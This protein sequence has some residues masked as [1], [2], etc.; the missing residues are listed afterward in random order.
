[1]CAKCCFSECYT[2]LNILVKEI[3]APSLGRRNIRI[4]HDW[5]NNNMQKLN[6]KILFIKSLKTSLSSFRVVG[7]N[8]SQHSQTIEIPDITL[9]CFPKLEHRT[10]FSKAQNTS[11]TGF[12]E[13]ELDLVQKSPTLMTISHINWRASA[14]YHGRKTVDSPTEL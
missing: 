5:T 11:E 10:L 8:I 3:F 2:S 13:I 12:W 6:I 7:Q 4:S 9:G 14:S 1:M